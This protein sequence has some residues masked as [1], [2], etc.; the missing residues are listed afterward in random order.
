[1]TTREKRKSALKEY[2]KYLLEELCDTGK[3][4]IF[5]E[6]F[7]SESSTGTYTKSCVTLRNNFST[8]HA[9]TTMDLSTASISM[10]QETMI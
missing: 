5:Y 7:T 1:M 6:I 8:S 10:K 3:G 2:I 4:E 9:E